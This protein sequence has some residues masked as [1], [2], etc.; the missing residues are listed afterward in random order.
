M[1]A[2]KQNYYDA[3]GVP[4]TAKLTD[5]GR[6]YNRHKADLQKEHAAP[7]PKRALKE[8]PANGTQEDERFSC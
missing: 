8:E 6:A 7:D 1:P 5:I 3:L 2:P 4:R